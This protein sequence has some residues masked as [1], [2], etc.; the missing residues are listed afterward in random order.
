M[1]FLHKTQHSIKK[2]TGVFL[3]TL[4]TSLAM[5]IASWGVYAIAD[6]DPHLSQEEILGVQLK[7]SSMLFAI[8]SSAVFLTVIFLPNR[9]SEQD[10]RA[11]AIEMC[12]LCWFGYIVFASLNGVVKAAS[13]DYPGLWML[14][15]TVPLLVGPAMA[16]LLFA[17]LFPGPAVSAVE[18]LSASERKVTYASMRHFQRSRLRN[19]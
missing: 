18:N 16:K 4:V 9:F 10:V 2:L 3:M 8:P 15:V 13:V 14:S 5:A 12:S 17:L 11:K 6:F 1:S 19:Y 7:L